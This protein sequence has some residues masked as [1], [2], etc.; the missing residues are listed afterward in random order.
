MRVHETGAFVLHSYALQEADKIGVFFTREYGK[1][2]GVARG[3]RKIRSRFGAS[4]EPLSEVWLTYQ[5]KEG[6]E[7]VTI[8]DC[9]LLSSLFRVEIV[10]E[11]EA[12]IHSIVELVDLF[13]AP[14]EPNEKVYRLI[15]AVRDCLAQGARDWRQLLLYFELWLLKLSG[16]FPDLDSCI[17]CGRM[18]PRWESVW[19][20]VQG[21]PEC[22]TCQSGSASVILTPLLRREI[23]F[24]L[25][26]SPARW[27]E[28]CRS[29]EHLRP[30][31][32]FL[33][34]LIRQALE[35]EVKAWRFITF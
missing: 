2:R 34:G 19:I 13:S 18:V 14:H 32:Q 12:L 6:R 16:F 33:C 9:E 15:G 3:A 24:M 25:T 23:S 30:F 27:M 20:T 11:T 28:R 17:R 5:E 10:P 22:R 35:T 1:I 8:R 31:H 29:L 21:R 7:L 4:L 26:M